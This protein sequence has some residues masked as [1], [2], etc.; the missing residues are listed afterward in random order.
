MYN[1]GS[2]QQKARVMR[3]VH[4]VSRVNTQPTK[5][6]CARYRLGIEYRSDRTVCHCVAGGLSRLATCTVPIY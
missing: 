1:V 2:W 6:L 4:G 5:R 3:E